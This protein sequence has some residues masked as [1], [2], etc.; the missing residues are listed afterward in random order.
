MA[1]YLESNPEELWWCNSHR[2]R[3]THIMVRWPGDEEHCC[4]PNLEGILLPCFAVNLTGICEIEEQ[5][6]SK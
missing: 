2:R 4:S 3:A 5:F 1:Q 6:V